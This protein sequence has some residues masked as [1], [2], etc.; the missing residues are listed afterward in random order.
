[1]SQAQRDMVYGRRG[2]GW[3]DGTGAATADAPRCEVCGRPMVAGQRKRHGICSPP[4]AC[5][6]APEDLV[7]DKALHAKQHTETQL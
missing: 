3:T 7:R 5:C 1:V 2:G 4:M 6:G